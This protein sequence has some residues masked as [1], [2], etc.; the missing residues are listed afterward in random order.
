MCHCDGLMVR[1]M[2]RWPVLLMATAVLVQASGDIDGK[3]GPGLN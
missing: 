2:G 1:A 3:S